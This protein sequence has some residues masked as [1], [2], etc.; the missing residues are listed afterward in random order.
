MIHQDHRHR[1][2]HTASYDANNVRSQALVWVDIQSCDVFLEALVALA[3]YTNKVSPL[4][5]VIH[6][7]TEHAILKRYLLCGD[8]RLG[9]VTQ[10]YGGF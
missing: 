1:D 10:T 4:L 6:C 8:D 7:W 5:E 9:C 2:I 3:W